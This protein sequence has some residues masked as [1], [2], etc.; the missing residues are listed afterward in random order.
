MQKCGMRIGIGIRRSM[1]CVLSL[2]D[3]IIIHILLECNHALGKLQAV[4]QFLLPPSL[5]TETGNFLR[6]QEKNET[7]S[8]RTGRK[9]R[10][11]REEKIR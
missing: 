6:G 5:R 8:C 9:T 3:C 1:L 10:L 7:L 2:T 11:E 4:L